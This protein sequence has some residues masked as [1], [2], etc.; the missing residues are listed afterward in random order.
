[1]ILCTSP[2]SLVKL[3][4]DVVKKG[5]KKIF[6]SA[7]RCIKHKHL[8]I[9]CQYQ[10]KSRC[11]AKLTFIVIWPS[12][13]YKFYINYTQEMY[14]TLPTV[15]GT[16][17]NML[18]ITSRKW[19]KEWPPIKWRARSS[20]FYQVYAIRHSKDCLGS[21]AKQPNQE[22]SACHVKTQLHGS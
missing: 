21:S 1:M 3:T 16:E 14:V 15:F 19:I 11:D 10:Q 2:Q 7:Q 4:A 13:I 8:Q 12:P 5:K 22:A 6:F 18:K 17:Q 9:I 20:V